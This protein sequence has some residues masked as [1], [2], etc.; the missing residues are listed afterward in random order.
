RARVRHGRTEALRRVLVADRAAPGPAVQQDAGA[1]PRRFLGLA[2]APTAERPLRRRWTPD[3]L[4]TT[5]VDR[6]PRH[7]RVPV[8]RSTAARLRGRGSAVG[9]RRRRGARAAARTGLRPT[10]GDRACR[11]GGAYD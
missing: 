11:R 5:R 8:A 3:R 9:A 10:P 4:A 1:R 6:R 7:V 2:T